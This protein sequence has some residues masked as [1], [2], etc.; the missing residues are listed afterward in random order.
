MNEFMKELDGLDE[1]IYLADIDTYELLYLNQGGLRQFG[2]ESR[3]AIAGC[4]CYEVLQKR[5]SPCD[6]CTNSLLC[7][8]KFY[9]WDIQN[10]VTGHQ[11]LLRDKLI[12]YEG[13]IVRMEIALDITR[14][15]SQEHQIKTLFENEQIAMECARSLQ[16]TQDER[17]AIDRT[18]AT[19]GV[20]LKGDRT[21]IFEIHDGVMDNT[22]EWCAS[23]ITAEKGNLQAVPAEVCHHWIEFFT[24]N[25]P[26]V[27]TD[28]EEHIQTEPDEYNR[29]KPQ[30]IQSLIV[31][32]LFDQKR[33]IGFLG[34]DNPPLENGSNVVE[35]LQL[36]SYFIQGALIRIQT[37]EKLRKMTFVDEMTGAKNR[38]AYIHDVEKLNAG[39]H[40][41]DNE[42]TIKGVGVIFADANG[43]KEINDSLGHE[44]GDKLL[45]R[46]A[47]K[48]MQVFSP[49]EVYRTGGDEFV[50][51]CGN[52][53]EDAFLENVEVLKQSLCSEGAGY[54]ASVG[55]GWSDNMVYM[56]EII[57]QA[58]ADMYDAKKRYYMAH[59][60]A[61][62]QN[63]IRH[64]EFET[65]TSLLIKD[66]DVAS[67]A[68]EL[69]HLI[70]EH[71][72]AQRVEILLAKTFVLFEQEYQK[73]Y[74]RRE[75][76]L[77]LQEQQK[78][79]V[80]QVIRD[81]QFYRQ[82][83][84]RGI[85]I[86][87][88]F[89]R[90]DWKTEKGKNCSV[91]FEAV[92]VF[93]QNEGRI[94]CAYMYCANIF[95]RRQ[96]ELGLEEE[97]NLTFL[98]MMTRTNERKPAVDLSENEGDLLSG[99]RIFADSFT[100]VSEKYSNVYFVDIQND[101]YIT[102]KSEGK[103]QKLVGAAGNY[104]GINRDYA[105]MYMDEVNKIRYLD[106]TS[107][108]NLMD[109]WK[110]G[111]KF[112]SM[113][114]AIT[115]DNKDPGRKVEIDIWLGE[116]D[117]IMT[118][119]FAFHN[120]GEDA[121]N[122]TV[123]EKDNLTGLLSY[124][125]FREAGQKIL[126]NSDTDVKEWAMVST[127]IQNFKYVNEVVGYQ[128]GDN[129]LK[130]FASN[131]RRMRKEEILHTR[132]TADRFLSFI[133]CGSEQDKIIKEI[134]DN[135]EQFDAAQK[136][137]NEDVK[138]VLRTGVYFLEKTCG[139][140]DTVIDRANITRQGIGQSI[141]SE[142]HIYREDIVKKNSIKNEILATMEKTLENG[143]FQIWLQP[144]VDLKTDKLC[145]A[146]VLIRWMHEN[147]VYFYP[148]DFIPIFESNGFIT[149][150]DFFVL[151]TTC[152]NLAKWKSQGYSNVGRLSVNLS[153]IDI[154]RVGIV[155]SITRI[156]DSYQIEHSELEFELTETAYF[157][158]SNV[159]MQVMEELKE[160]G[161][162][163][164]VDDFGSGYSVM[165]MLINM[166]ASIVKIDREFMLNSIKSIKGSAFLERL[167]GIIHELD[168]RVLCEGIETEEQY[169]MLRD[170]GCDEGQGYYFSKPIPVEAFFEK[171]IKSTL[172]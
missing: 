154:T 16:D 130:N 82:H 48:I 101:A 97:G 163:T 95:F 27:I 149:S 83:V 107:R 12:D 10:A 47:S 52:L 21:Y 6:F 44:E 74:Q 138:I 159:T 136:Q 120:I 104:T 79:N 3:E 127:D 5:H 11:Y 85:S 167:I 125:R 36:L 170:M 116:L 62:Q 60:Y 113:D 96:Y 76:V 17:Q 91:P 172:I 55:T 72:D 109:N 124:A 37:N 40:T 23:G 146:E 129:I 69:L 61:N 14:L 30:G 86:L 166:P 114:F 53:G 81:L 118:S 63:G 144:K 111:N 39:I 165:N 94:K 137:R 75:A 57:N 45:I 133:R 106:F 164:S 31:V 142:I 112:M 98:N 9:E 169:K 15:A 1:L 46:I 18:L 84:V 152:Q 150:L 89:G 119:I 105:E 58:E 162:V 41:L 128:E 168:Y 143:G 93:V 78:K 145:G 123:I 87:S 80:K 157:K 141:S 24:K 122:S 32:P 35:I 28:L 99:F 110:N 2:L 13:K 171:Y 158:N 77:Y 108:K 34:I 50:V 68:S 20:R 126:D 115:K 42:K 8:E 156:V 160:E 22:Y 19:L 56:E 151:E 59:Y 153:A 51:L 38:N 148:D 73:I 131:L 102:L 33:L 49:S 26:Y 121:G 29:L 155:D 71:W 147:H 132:V 140:I 92:L 70:L 54:D 66:T 88:C 117:G 7:Q 43:L 134:R 65:Y 25:K 100:L 90:L 139:S 135:I 103:F 64:S 4:K 161:F 67:V